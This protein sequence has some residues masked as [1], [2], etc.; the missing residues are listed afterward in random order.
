MMEL[1]QRKRKENELMSLLLIAHHVVRA[2]VTTNNRFD[3]GVNHQSPKDQF[4]AILISRKIVSRT[5]CFKA[6]Q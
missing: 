6:I 1:R 5:H 2:T 4:R 3:V